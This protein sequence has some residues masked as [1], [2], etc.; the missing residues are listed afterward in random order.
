MIKVSDG[1]A[2]NKIRDLLQVSYVT[3]LL[4]QSGMAD[5]H[6]IN[7]SASTRALATLLAQLSQLK[8]TSPS[9]SLWM[10]GLMKSAAASEAD[11]I[12][13]W[14]RYALDGLDDLKPTPAIT[15]TFKSIAGKVGYLTKDGG[16]WFF[17]VYS[18]GDATIVATDGGKIYG[19]AFAIPTEKAGKDIKPA[20]FI[21]PHDILPLIRSVHDCI[22]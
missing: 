16:N 21:A 22:G 7:W 18:M 12:G 3:S 5:F 10:L 11:G 9:H 2:R 15:R 17:R 6:P 14:T 20:D 19:L 13:T 4:T 1:N 8:L